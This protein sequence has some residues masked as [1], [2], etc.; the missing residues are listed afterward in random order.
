MKPEVLAKVDYL[1]PNEHEAAI[2]FGDMSVEEMLR[3]I[4]ASW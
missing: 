4:P 3:N 2:L 1:T